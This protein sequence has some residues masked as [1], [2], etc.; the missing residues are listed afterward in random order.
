[1]CFT[2][3]RII[4]SNIKV[5]TNEKIVETAQAC[6][7]KPAHSSERNLCGSWKETRLPK[8]INR[9][10]KWIIPRLFYFSTSIYMEFR[11]LPIIA[12]HLSCRILS[13]Q[14]FYWVSKFPIPIRIDPES[15]LEDEKIS[16]LRQ[17]PIHLVPLSGHE[18]MLKYTRGG[19]QRSYWNPVFSIRYLRHHF[20]PRMHSIC[21]CN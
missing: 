16:I 21:Q 9:H 17:Q 7:I 11:L 20:I 4:V 12:S 13:S 10:W 2:K 5:S 8:S 19:F 15:Y 3:C 14:S 1:M 6:L 18:G